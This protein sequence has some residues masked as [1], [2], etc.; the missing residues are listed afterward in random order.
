MYYKTL[1]EKY[2]KM[3]KNWSSDDRSFNYIS[4]YI[5]I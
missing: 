3:K 1:L 5:I 2:E 4:C